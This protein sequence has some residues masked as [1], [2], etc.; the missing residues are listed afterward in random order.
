MFKNWSALS[1]AQGPQVQKLLERLTG[2]HTV[3]NVFIGENCLYYYDIV[4]VYLN[5]KMS[6]SLSR[7]YLLPLLKTIYSLSVFFRSKNMNGMCL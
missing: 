2:Q 7:P 1:G 3:P 4:S 6:Y 5:C